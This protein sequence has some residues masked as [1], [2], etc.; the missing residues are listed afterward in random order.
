MT[1]S[2]L[3]PAGSGYELVAEHALAENERQA[4]SGRVRE[5]RDAMAPAARAVIETL[6]GSLLAGYPTG[7]GH[8]DEAE[9]V[10]KMFVQSLQG[11]PAWAV[12][13]A[14]SS[15]NRGEAAGKNTTF[16]PSPADMR[17]LAL[18]AANP[19][20][21]EQK[22]L[23]LILAAEVIPEREDEATRAAVAERVRAF[24]SALGEPEAV[25][26]KPAPRAPEQIGDEVKALGLRLSDEAKAA[27]KPMMSR[28]EYDAW[29]D[30]ATTST[31]QTE[32]AA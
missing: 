21:R 9:A 10:V 14:C 11:L 15:W 32:R 26:A 19:F 1:Y 23:G 3:T 22:M 13:S 12:S 6:V 8:R 5:L 2:R 4:L 31:S 16:A 24:A 27:L 29:N 30:A 20:V 7:R 25:I 17:T 18:Q 28:A